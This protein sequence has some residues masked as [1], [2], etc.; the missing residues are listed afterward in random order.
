MSFYVDS[1]E[2]LEDDLKEYKTFVKTNCYEFS[3]KE[4]LEK[5]R[6]EVTPAWA[7][8]KLV[9]KIIND[10]DKVTECLFVIY[11]PILRVI[12]KRVQYCDWGIDFMFG[13][14]ILLLNIFKYKK[15]KIIKNGESSNLK[16]IKRRV[17]WTA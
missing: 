6:E 9:S 7:I 8:V 15:I 11:L 17:D 4:V 12:I 5:A 1:K 14:R 16:G 13:C 2:G 3:L 10:K